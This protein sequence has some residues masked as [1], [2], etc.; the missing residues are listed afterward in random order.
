MNT[1][2]RLVP[3][4]VVAML[5]ISVTAC[6]GAHVT[7]E[8]FSL[9]NCGVSLLMPSQPDEEKRAAQT[10]GATLHST[11]YTATVGNS[12]YVVACNT[13]AKA[14]MRGANVNTMLDDAAQGAMRNMDAAL[15]SQMLIE[16]DGHPGREVIGTAHFAGQSAI[17]RAR[18]YVVGNRLIQTL[19][20]GTRDRLSEGDAARYLS[21]LKL[22]K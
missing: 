4:F 2:R 15:D 6:G 19:V 5:A 16:L 8:P 17:A 20:V 21:S 14:P 13:F 12:I 3:L 10:A 9:A 22:L 7:F 18:V 1:C 11:V